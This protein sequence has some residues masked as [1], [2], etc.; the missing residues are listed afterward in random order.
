MT[1]AHAPPTSN[2]DP[3][4]L[5]ITLSV[6]ASQIARFAELLRGAAVVA[7][8]AVAEAP[9]LRTKAEIAKDLRTSTGSVD[10]WVRAG[11]P[12]ER[13]GDRRRFDLAAVRKWLAT[14]K[15][16]DAPANDAKLDVSRVAR[17]AGLRA[18]GG[19]S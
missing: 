5:E 9:R 17:K 13:V 3:E 14:H 7:P 19:A 2:V 18:A 6:P 15:T 10:R 1:K 8:P 16:V 4:R 11:C 12:C